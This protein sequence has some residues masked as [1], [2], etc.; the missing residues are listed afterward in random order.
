MS[1]PVALP[2]LLLL[3]A[4]SLRA[5]APDTLRLADAHAA[6]ALGDPRAGQIALRDAQSALRLR[7]LA[8]ERRPTLGVESQAQYQSDVTAVPV[9]RPDGTALPGPP[10]DTYDARLVAQQ[11]LHDPTL[12]PRQ[13]VERAQREESRA[14]T[15][16]ALYAQRQEVNDAFFSAALL[17]TRADALRVT[18]ASLD[19]Q[20]RQTEARRRAGAA[21]AGDVAMVEVELLRRQQTLDAILADRRAALATLAALT[22]HSLADDVVLVLPDLGELVSRTRAAP[23][24]TMRPEFEQFARTRDRLARQADALAATRRPRVSAFGRAGYGRPGLDALSRDVDEYWLAGLLVQWSPTDWGTTERSRET[25]AIEQRVVATEEGAFARAL[26]R[27]VAR[28]LAAMDRLAAI[29]AADA[30][31]VALRERIEREA[32]ARRDEGA[33]STA[34]YI[35]RENDVLEAR[36]AA[37]THRVELAYAQA[38]YLTTLGVELR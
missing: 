34:E 25:L 27:A 3:T 28:D 15:R 19:A 8:A 23:A 38:R 6:A 13:A 14:R 1:A 31:I 22:G 24:L 4:A 33:L 20:L 37:A 5:Q 7:S 35:A 17:G 12:A 16:I 9:R 21:L 18:Q 26:E 2:L 10:H 11:L 36:I 29:A 32:R 30:R